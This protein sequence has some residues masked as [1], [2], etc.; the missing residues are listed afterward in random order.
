MK[1]LVREIVGEDAITLED[2][3]AVHDRIKPE[4]AAG[5]QVELDFDGV[6]VFASPF[7][8]AAIGQ[9]L[10]DIQPEDLNGLLRVQ[11]LNAVGAG[12]MSRVIENAKRYY[13]SPDYR[14]AQQRVLE[15]I[16]KEE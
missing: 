7:F 11:N 14:K 15:E 12:L 16:F 6:T 5:H 2:G 10:E 4:L 9:L 1:C 3:Q 13:S 8:N